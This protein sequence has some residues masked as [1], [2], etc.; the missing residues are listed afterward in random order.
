MDSHVSSLRNFRNGMQVYGQDIIP[1]GG[2]QAWGKKAQALYVDVTNGTAGGTGKNWNSAVNSLA[3]AYALVNSVSAPAY[4]YLAPGTYTGAALA[5]AKPFVHIIGTGYGP[6]GQG[7]TMTQPDNTALFTLSALADGG[8]IQGLHV[9][10]AD[11]TTV[12]D[13][14]SDS[15]GCL[16][17]TIANNTFSC[18]SAADI[19]TCI[20]MAS[21]HL[22]IYNNRFLNVWKPIDSAGE[23]PYICDNYIFQTTGLAATPIAI[24]IS[25]G[26][27]GE[28]A[29][30]VFNCSL[31]TN[32]TGLKLSGTNN[33]VH[34]NLF[35]ESV[36]DP[37]SEGSG[38][39]F[40]EN[41][42]TG[43]Y[44]NI[45]GTSAAIDTGATFKLVV[46]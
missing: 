14:I 44:V 42:I 21:D 18:A 31:T 3:L 36:N 23:Y 46:T 28:I 9:L 34:H 22:S 13:T 35:N 11:Q 43:D 26:D 37:I 15:D 40:F 4:I 10:I 16:Y 20:D 6:Y 30:N 5:I 1:G 2:A 41:Y 12:A 29:R 19:M 17:Y 32:D 25:D 27:G 39:V 24:Y 8:S 7:V 45:D 33:I 38:N